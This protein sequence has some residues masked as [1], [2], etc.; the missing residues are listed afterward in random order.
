MRPLK[1]PYLTKPS[2]INYC[3]IYSIIASSAHLCYLDI[4]R[5]I[6]LYAFIHIYMYIY[7]FVYL[8]IYIF[9]YTYIL[10]YVSIFIFL[11]LHVYISKI[12]IIITVYIFLH[13]Y[14]CGR[15]HISRPIYLRMFTHIYT[16][17]P[18]H[19]YIFLQPYSCASLHTATHIYQPMSTYFCTCACLHTPTPVIPC[20]L[21]YF[22]TVYLCMFTYFYT[23]ISLHVHILLHPYTCKFTY[24]SN[25]V[26][27][28][29]YRFLHLPI[30]ACVHNS[31]PVFPCVITYIYTRIA[32]AYLLTSTRIAIHVLHSTYMRM[33]I[34]ERVCL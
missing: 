18:A 14:T 8:H 24:F 13:P 1:V 20:K 10:I 25:H 34:T 26:P 27:A 11:Y 6:S 23:H 15:L 31:T 19:V 28:K 4:Y 9:I 2:K 5:Y 7:I 22:C 12:Y 30:Y 32:F 3:Q 29:D 33:Y 16:H 17:V 21:T